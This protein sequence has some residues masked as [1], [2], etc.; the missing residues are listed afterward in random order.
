MS[1]DD[2]VFLD[3]LSSVPN[4]IWRYSNEVADYID[5]QAQKAADTIR[6]ALSSS[7]WIPESARPKP[8]P[9]K[10][11]V[12]AVSLP[13]SIHLQIQNWVTKH[14]LWSA[15][16]VVAFGGVAYSMIS[17][18]ANR[19]KRRAK[20][21]GNG[22]RLE[23]VV[24]A[25]SPSEP[26]TKSIALDLERRG[27]IVYIV[28]N[29]IEEEVLVHNEARPDIKPLMVDIVDPISAK[30]SL[31]RFTEF[32]Q[33][34][35][36]AFQGAKHHH[37]TFRSLILIPSLNYPSA[38]IATLSPSTISDVLNTRLFNTILTTQ[39]FLPTLAA[40]PLQH[41]HSQNGIWTQ[42]PKPS[43]LVL[44]PSI[45]PSLNPAFH[46][47]ESSM[48]AALTS[49][50]QVLSAELSPLSIP[51]TQLQ[52]GTFDFSNFSAKNQLQTLQSQRAETLRWDESARQVYG[53]NFVALSSGSV[54]AAKGCGSTGGLSKG[55]S[56]RELNNAV[57]DAMVRNKGG[58]IRVGQGSKLYGFIGNWVPRGLVGWMLG[59]RR[60]NHL[61]NEFG[62]GSSPSSEDGYGYTPPGSAGSGLGSE[63]V[64][65]YGDA[66][67][68]DGK[69]AEKFWKDHP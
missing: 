23:V 63:Y 47:L 68:S 11:Q 56:L 3:V 19:K 59:L 45:I 55:S 7:K 36:A 49:F 21:A 61:S 51:V 1:A 28:C 9:P 66:G 43:V 64:P 24:I 29:T 8:P 27:F 13:G 10:F 60:V 4:D 54:G 40:L 20:R 62:R 48:V 35:H 41:P 25:G 22:A 42:P 65:V 34:P 44:T 12:S 26:I 58:I 38:P 52:L 50:T 18:K 30:G 16:I 53:K 57:F 31:E 5:K 17:K 39:T 37:L 2:Q 32:L 46:V 6:E 69:E 15:A 67:G 33:L 14:K